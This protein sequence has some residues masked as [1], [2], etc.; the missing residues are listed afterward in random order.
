MTN[1]VEDEKLESVAGVP[2]FRH[3]PGTPRAI[4][5]ERNP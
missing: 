4:H 5:G 3:G 1:L 2:P